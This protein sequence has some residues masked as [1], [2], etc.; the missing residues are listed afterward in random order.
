MARPIH[1]QLLVV[2]DASELTFGQ[3]KRLAALKCSEESLSRKLR[4]RQVLFTSEAEA[5]ARALRCEVRFSGKSAAK[6]G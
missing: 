2:H 3:L 5:I 1:R 6:A 4:G